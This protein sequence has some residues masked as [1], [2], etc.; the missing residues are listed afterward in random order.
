MYSIKLKGEVIGKKNNYR[1]TKTG[2]FYRDPKFANWEEDALWQIKSHRIPKLAG[3][4]SVKIVLYYFRNRDLDNCITS[5]LDV[6]QK[7]GVIDNDSNVISIQ[8]V[9]VKR[10]TGGADIDIELL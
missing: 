9:K 8:A 2:G 3:Q 4:Y 1:V 10:K 5:L 7:S 6:L